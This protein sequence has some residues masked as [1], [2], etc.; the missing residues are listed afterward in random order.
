MVI[1]ATL[2]I[3]AYALY[4]IQGKHAAAHLIYTIPFVVMGI[5]RYYIIT[6]DENLADGNPSDVL[7]AD[8]FMI[9]N[10][11]LWLALCAGLI[12]YFQPGGA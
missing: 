10:I 11:V 7:I 12:L 4:C 8:K 3:M 9:V 5:F 2:T 6:H 1:S